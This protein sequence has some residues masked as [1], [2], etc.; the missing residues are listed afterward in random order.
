MGLVVSQKKEKDFAEQ[1]HLA[2]TSCNHLEVAIKN[3]GKTKKEIKRKRGLKI[4]TD[5][6]ELNKCEIT[7]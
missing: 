4:I 6:N 7:G 5:H 1:L 2:E 3:Q